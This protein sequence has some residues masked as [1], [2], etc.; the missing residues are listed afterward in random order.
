MKVGL[1]MHIEQK[2]WKESA[3]G[4]SNLSELYL[5]LGDVVS[6][7]HFGEQSVVFADRS[8]DDFS[9]KTRNARLADVYCQ[10]GK[11]NDAYELF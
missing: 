6:A 5:L 9:K 7:K 10:V 3:R 2:N 1:D 8:G 4:A 11:L